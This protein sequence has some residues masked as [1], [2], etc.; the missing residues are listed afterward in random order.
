MSK[1]KGT[2]K[3]AL[4]MEM[5]GRG[6]GQDRAQVTEETPDLLCQ[7]GESTSCRPENAASLA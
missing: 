3:D 7:R 6:A 4:Y 5:C 2:E 1:E